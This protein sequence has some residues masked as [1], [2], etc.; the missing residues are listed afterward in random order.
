MNFSLPSFKSETSET[1][2]RCDNPLSENTVLVRDQETYSRPVNILYPLK[3][4]SSLG[5]QP[6]VGLGPVHGFVTVNFSGVGSLAQPPTWRT[7]DYISSSPYPVTC[8]A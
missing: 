7:R 8:P 2:Y 6:C 1:P 5:Q 4:S 3:F